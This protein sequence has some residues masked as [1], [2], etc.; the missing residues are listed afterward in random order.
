MALVDVVKTALEQNWRMVDAALDGLDDA[1]LARQPSSQCNSIAWLLWHMN[2]VVDTIIQ[3][4]R[5]EPQLWSRDGWS[6]QFGMCD[7]PGERGRGW[8]AEQLAAWQAPAREVQLQYYEA[9]KTSTR[10]YF[11]SLT[12]ADLDKPV[13]VP[14][15]ADPF[16][17]ADILGVMVWDTIAHGGQ[18]A[19]LSGYYRD[20]IWSR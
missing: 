3:S 15:R 8:T 11:S 10:A 4:L 12:T 16:I 19:Y 18:I 5:G 7:D 2:R 14:P 13:I 17:G 9:V 6:H 20:K 1:T